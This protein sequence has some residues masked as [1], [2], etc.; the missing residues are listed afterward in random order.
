MGN[1]REAADEHLVQRAIGAMEKNTGMVHGHRRAHARG[2]VFHAEFVP[3]RE[4]AALTT[5]EHFQGEPV[6]ALVRLSNAAGTPY[7]PDRR[8][9]GGG[10]VLGLAIRVELAAGGHTTWAAASIPAFPARTAQE[11]IDLTTALRPGRRS[12]RPGLVRIARFLA[13]HRHA[14]AGIKG[15][16][17]QPAVPSFANARFN[18]L[19]AYYAVDPQGNRQAFRYSWMP[20]AGVDK[21]PRRSD[22]DLPPQYLISEIKLR[23]RSQPVSW[24]LQ[25]Q[26]AAP[27]DPVDDPSQAWPE[28]RRKVTAGRL[29]LGDLAEDQSAADRIV[30]DPTNVVPGIELSDDPILRFRPLVYEE[31][32]TRRSAESKPTSTPE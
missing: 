2:V 27:G 14:L 24:T 22:N 12:R 10:S 28:D 23:V 26:L 1:Q 32:F 19:H 9:G 25:F 13:T 7:A 29:T 31:S 5:A 11:F 15:T 3:S 20:D 21:L 4:I 17:G 16:A 30:F 8:P 6:H 18:S